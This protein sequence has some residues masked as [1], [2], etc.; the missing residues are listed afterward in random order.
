MHP[1]APKPLEDIRS[2]AD[3]VRS[4]TQGVGLLEFSARANATVAKACMTFQ[5]DVARVLGAGAFRKGLRAMKATDSTHVSAVRPRQLIGSADVD[6]ALAEALPN[7]APLGL[8]G[9]AT[10][11][12]SPP[13]P[14]DRDASSWERRQCWRG[15]RKLA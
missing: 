14:L 15:G 12:R 4:V 8:S 11:G 10:P 2:A 7:A 1:R 13:G 3:F 6:G 9:G 5:A